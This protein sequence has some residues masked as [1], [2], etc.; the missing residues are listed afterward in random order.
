MIPFNIGVAF[1]TAATEQIMFI[2][3]LSLEPFRLSCD[4]ED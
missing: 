1:Q 4:T 2:I 3:G